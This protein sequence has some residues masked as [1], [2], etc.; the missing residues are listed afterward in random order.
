MRAI[1]CILIAIYLMYVARGS[2]TET[3]TMELL[4]GLMAILS[5]L[6]TAASIVLMI[7]GL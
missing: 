3:P 1:A 2:S 5:F 7:A 4:T 6:F